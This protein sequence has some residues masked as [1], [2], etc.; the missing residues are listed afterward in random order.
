MKHVIRISHNYTQH[1]ITLQLND[2]IKQ[3]ELNHNIL[4]TTYLL[5]DD[6]LVVIF[7]ITKDKMV[8]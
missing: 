4:D 3:L 8:N 2:A 7:S 1:Q 5:N 6:F